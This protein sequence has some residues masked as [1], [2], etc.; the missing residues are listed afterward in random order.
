MRKCIKKYSNL[1]SFATIGFIGFLISP[2]LAEP[3]SRK[4]FDASNFFSLQPTDHFVISK[5]EKESAL[6]LREISAPPATTDDLQLDFESDFLF[7]NP[8]QQN[9]I[10]SQ[11]LKRVSGKKNKT[12]TAE[13]YGMQHDP[14]LVLRIPHYSNFS[15]SQPAGDFSIYVEILPSER[16]GSIFSR[17]AYRNGIQYLFAL[18]FEKGYLQLKLLN[19]F[20]KNDSG[21]ELATVNFRRTSTEQILPREKNRILVTYSAASSKMVLYLNGLVQF[22]LTSPQKENHAFSLDLLPLKNSELLL[23]RDYRGQADNIVI[24][25]QVL[26]SNLESNFPKLGTYGDRYDIAT[27]AATTTIFDMGYSRSE[28]LSVRAD[29]DIPRE[30]QFKIQYRCHDKQFSPDL[31]ELTL[32]FST[33]GK[34]I[35]C[36]FVQ[37]KIVMQADNLGK[38]SPQLRQFVLEYQK[39]PPPPKPAALTI[40]RVGS[41]E[42]SVFIHPLTDFDVVHGGKYIIYYGHEKYKIEGAFYLLKQTP[43]QPI[44]LTNDLIAQNKQWANQKPRFHHRYPVFEKELGLYFWVTACD[45]AYGFEQEFADHESLPS[46]AVFVRFE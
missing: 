39:N 8:A 34:S 7:K 6:S 27:K 13:F 41:D 24:S 33:F 31:R 40:T 3:F 25:N 20:K 1:K 23:F 22:E 42:V 10:V 28:I 32:P 35:R 38:H 44:A 37:F 5:Y 17:E 26:D 21:E 4:N 16:S 29:A 12:M 30:T 36:R 43:L 11:N 14:G 19:L 2:V 18:D 9:L 15:G 45:S 46:E